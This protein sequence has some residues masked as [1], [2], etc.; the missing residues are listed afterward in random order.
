MLHFQI[1]QPEFSGR[2]CLKHI[3]INTLEKGKVLQ[4]W[5]TINIIK[6]IQNQL[7]ANIIQ[8]VVIGG[9]DR[10][11]FDDIRFQI[12]HNWNDKHSSIGICISKRKKEKKKRKWFL[13]F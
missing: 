4:K 1:Q 5:Q 13:F 6:Q 7:V 9:S 3:S 2:K 8:D 10:D 12:S 11:G